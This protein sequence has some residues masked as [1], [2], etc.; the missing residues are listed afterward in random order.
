MFYH[1]SVYTVLKESNGSSLKYMFEV[2]SK[3]KKNVI[4]GQDVYVQ[5]AHNAALSASITGHKPI[6][7]VGEPTLKA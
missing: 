3:L 7:S 5:C 6:N 4:V 2:L 1:L